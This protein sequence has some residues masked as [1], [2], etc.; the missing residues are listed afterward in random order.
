MIPTYS[1]KVKDKGNKFRTHIEFWF[2]LSLLSRLLTSYLPFDLLLMTSSPLPLSSSFP[3]FKHE[4]SPPLILS[5][6]YPKEHI[7]IRSGNLWSHFSVVSFQHS[8]TDQ[9]LLSAGF[10]MWTLKF[11]FLTDKSNLASVYSP[12]YCISIPVGRSVSVSSEL[13]VP[14]QHQTWCYLLSLTKSIAHNRSRFCLCSWLF[15][16]GASH[17]QL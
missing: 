3:E 1:F 7:F 2:P 10:P 11:C 17:L 6:K 14:L 16:F 15:Y 5:V 13:A 12:I 4:F 8:F 9:Y